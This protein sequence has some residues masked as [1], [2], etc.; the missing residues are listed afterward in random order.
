MAVSTIPSNRMPC[1]T[2]SHNCG[3]DPN[4]F[5]SSNYSLVMRGG[6]YSHSLVSFDVPCFERRHFSLELSCSDQLKRFKKCDQSVLSGAENRSKSYTAWAQIPHALPFGSH[7]HSTKERA[8]S[9]GTVQRIVPWAS[10]RGWHEYLLYFLFFS[11][12]PAPNLLKVSVPR[13]NR[14]RATWLQHKDRWRNGSIS[15]P[16]VTRRAKSGRMGGGG[17][18]AGQG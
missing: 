12:S 11:L 15:L 1:N 18:R 16:G 2:W 5:K 14:I 6:K 7:E 9:S 17:D 10:T 13:P 4:T 3:R 8:F